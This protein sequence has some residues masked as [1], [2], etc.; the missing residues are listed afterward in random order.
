MSEIRPETK[1]SV[2][3]LTSWDLYFKRIG[4][5]GDIKV[6]ANI[7]N[8]SVMTFEE[9]QMQIQMSNIMFAGT[10]GQGSHARLKIVDDKVR[11]MLFGVEEEEKIDVLT[12]DAVKE[13]LA[14]KAKAAFTKRLGELVNTDA[15]KRMIVELAK[16]AGAADV[17]A[18]KIEA[19]E[20]LSGYSLTVSEDT[21]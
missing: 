9:V 13:L 15:E 12:L 14:I 8:Y 7:K 11:A 17:E 20:K 16:T 5:I 2:D 18:W 1:I 3:N 10:D 6:P 4:G 19:I 21:E